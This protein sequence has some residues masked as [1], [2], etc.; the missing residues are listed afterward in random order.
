MKALALLFFAAALGWTA[1]AR[2]NECRLPVAIERPHPVLST[3]SEPRRMM[4]ISGYTLAL[5]WA[6]EYCYAHRRESGRDFE[7]GA[8]ARFGFV[9]H[10][11]WPDGQDG[12]WPQYCRPVA[13]LPENVI[14]AN[15]CAT[16]SPQLLQHEYAKHGSC[17]AL[18]PADYFRLSTGLYGRLRFPDMDALAR[19]P[20][21]TVGAFTQA[22]ARANP[23][24][25][26]RMVRIALNKRGWLEEV[27]FCLDRARR[28]TRCT[29]PGSPGVAPASARVRIAP[30]T[31][32]RIAPGPR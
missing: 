29:G 15:L 20:G 8:G 31:S 21:L 23:G 1:V 25:E 26:P 19:R 30:L 11:L 32:A 16:P 28:F 22:L 5:T 14:R 12:K 27:R 18:A 10:G 24:V 9:L 6:P 13:L 17:T 2:A 3:P 4:P 7:C